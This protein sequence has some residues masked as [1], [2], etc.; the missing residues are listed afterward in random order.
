MVTKTLPG[1]LIALSA[2]FIL[3]LN[4]AD[5]SGKNKED[6][7]D[8]SIKPSEA[9]VLG[10]I[11]GVTEYLPVSST[12]HLILASNALGLSKY[13]KDPAEGESP[14]IKVPSLDAYQIVIQ[15]GAILAVLGLYRKHVFS[16]LRGV[17]GKD[18]DGVRLLI[19]L[20]IAFLPAAIVGLLTRDFL[21]THLFTPISVAV[22]LALGGVLMIVVERW[23]EGDKNQERQLCSNV[24][25]LSYL[26]ALSIGLFQCLALCPGTSRSMV[27]IVGALIVGVHIV[28]AAEFSFLLALPTLGAATFY[29]GAMNWNTLITETGGTSLFLGLA[30]SMIVAAI[31]IK[32]LLH[33]LKSHGLTPFGFYRI[34]IAAVVL[35]YFTV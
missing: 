33:W 34:G 7:S 2:F 5:A 24:V 22:A 29:E 11:E 13:K 1:L 17:M 15:L 35:L 26:Q 27:T 25:D 30:I 18:P 31:S 20:I 14:L 19:L 4:T 10:V 3:Q 28:A 32:W 6:L 9:I 12:G 21:Q 23:Y 16:I 8:R